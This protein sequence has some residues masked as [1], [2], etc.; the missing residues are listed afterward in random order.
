MNNVYA[1]LVNLNQSAHY[2]HWSIFTISI[3]NLVIIAVM[4]LIFGLALIMPFPGG[5]KFLT[6]TPSKQKSIKMRVCLMNTQRCGL[7][8]Y[9]TIG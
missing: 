7:T 2:L 1:S 6:M 3:A 8:D 9:D 4:V 5:K